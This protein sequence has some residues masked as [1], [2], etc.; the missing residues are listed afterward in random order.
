M[1][2]NP[3]YLKDR[4]RGYYNKYPEF[5][6]WEDGHKAGM[7]QGKMDMLLGQSELILEAKQAMLEEVVGWINQH[8]NRWSD[9]EWQAFV[10]SLSQ[11]MGGVIKD[12]N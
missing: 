5:Q 8:W 7:V 10:A 9:T 1:E 3:Y 6:I 2:A 12:G 4:D 11:G